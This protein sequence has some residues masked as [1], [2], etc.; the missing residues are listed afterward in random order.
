MNVSHLE[1]VAGMGPLFGTGKRTSWYFNN[2]IHL[3]T[4]ADVRVPVREGQLVGLWVPDEDPVP[5]K[6]LKGNFG[7]QLD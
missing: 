6:H 4:S 3:S 5:V 7:G 2:V 1:F